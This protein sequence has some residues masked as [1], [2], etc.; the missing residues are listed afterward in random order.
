MKKKKLSTSLGVLMGAGDDMFTNPFSTTKEEIDS[1]KL[2]EENLKILNDAVDEDDKQNGVRRTKKKKKSDIDKLIDIDD[3]LENI[4]S[5]SSISFD[6]YLDNL[7]I[8]DAIEDASLKRELTVLGRKFARE[9]AI[10]GDESEIARAFNPQES[11]LKS[12]L[13]DVSADLIAVQKDIEYIRGYRTKN[14]KAL[15]ELIQTKNQLQTTCLNIVKELNNS[16]KVQIDL[17]A[18]DKAKDMNESTSQ[19]SAR[20]LKSLFSMDRRELS[21]ALSADSSSYY[22]NDESYISEDAGE[23]SY[24]AEHCNDAN[25]SDGDKFIKYENSGAHYVLVVNEGTDV[26]QVITEDKDGNLL[27]DY[28]L[29]TD[30][31]DL[32]FD[33]NYQSKTATDQL[34]RNYVLRVISENGEEE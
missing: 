27:A 30:V 24:C 8:G 14:Y 4:V 7:S 21:N 28:P 13:E 3:T 16:K 17:K 11:Y 33:I 1:T 20:A 31:N 10:T 9:T 26:K 22:N 29:P 19:V 6:D 15:S 32:D 23:E 2:M 12:Q 18:K 5:E 34:H 25:E